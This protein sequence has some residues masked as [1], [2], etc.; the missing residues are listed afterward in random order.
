[1]KERSDTEK[2][3]RIAYGMKRSDKDFQG[4]K[5]DVLFLDD[6]KTRRREWHDMVDFYFRQGD[7]LVVLSEVDIGR[8][9]GLAAIK[10]NLEKYSVS[11]DVVGEP[12]KPAA[13]KKPG[14]WLRASDEQKETLCHYWHNP[15]YSREYCRDVAER[16]GLGRPTDNQFN[17]LCGNRNQSD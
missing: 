8:G 11:I 10:A 3:R 13:P 2:P 1:M 12:E 4:V 16:V 15:I 9:K 17:R 5:Y 14:K 6:A 7:T